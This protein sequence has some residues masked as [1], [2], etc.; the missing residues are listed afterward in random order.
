M[1]IVLSLCGYHKIYLLGCAVF[2]FYANQ[3]IGMEI[4]LFPFPRHGIDTLFPVATYISSM[5]SFPSYHFMYEFGIHLH[6]AFLTTDTNF[7]HFIFNVCTGTLVMELLILEI[8]VLTDFM[9]GV[10]SVDWSL[11]F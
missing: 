4:A 11:C 2:P 5:F 6:Y 3:E 8:K 9:A 7:Y 10:M 1:Y